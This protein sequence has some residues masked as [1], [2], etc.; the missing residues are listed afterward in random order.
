MCN[1][2]YVHW[3]IRSLFNLQW[4]TCASIQNIGKTGPRAERG[5]AMAELISFL[6]YLDDLC[7]YKGAKKNY[8]V[9]LNSSNFSFRKDLLEEIGPNNR[10]KNILAGGWEAYSLVL[11]CGNR[12]KM[13]SGIQKAFVS[14]P[15]Y[16]W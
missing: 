4:R 15:D 1:E 16:G 9:I 11:L 6:N 10:Q 8:I 7:T 5:P 2:K 3:K 14:K 12:D 13:V